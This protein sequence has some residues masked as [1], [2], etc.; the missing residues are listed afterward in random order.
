MPCLQQNVDF[1]CVLNLHHATSFHQV[2][3]LCHGMLQ[4]HDAVSVLRVLLSY[5]T[6]SECH[7]HL[8]LVQESEMNQLYWNVLV[9]TDQTNFTV[10]NSLHDTHFSQLVT[11]LLFLK[12]SLKVFQA[13]R[14]LLTVDRQEIRA[15][16][17]WGSHTV[18]SSRLGIEPVTVDDGSGCHNLQG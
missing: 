8:S 12:V 14:P 13:F 4:E 15:V 9:A 17:Q 2:F 11:L 1:F 10:N 18:K 7:T 16:R 3:L 5:T 6:H